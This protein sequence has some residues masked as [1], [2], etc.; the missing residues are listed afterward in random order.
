LEKLHVFVGLGKPFELVLGFYGKIIFNGYNMGFRSK[1]S[2]PYM[3]GEKTRSESSKNYQ[4][5]KIAEPCFK[6]TRSPKI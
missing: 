6:M 2:K 3:F 4:R 5:L 1:P